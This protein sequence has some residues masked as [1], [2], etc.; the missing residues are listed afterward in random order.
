MKKQNENDGVN[1]ALKYFSPGEMK[2]G[3]I[4]CK[5]SFNKI[6]LKK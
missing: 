6:I 1:L 3:K 2:I 4:E 5:F